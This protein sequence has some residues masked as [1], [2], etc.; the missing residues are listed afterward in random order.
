MLLSRFWDRIRRFA[1]RFVGSAALA[2]AIYLVSGFLLPSVTYRVLSQWH[3]GVKVTIE[4]ER[5]SSAGVS[6]G[7]QVR[8][9]AD[10]K[11]LTFAE[12]S[13]EIDV[14]VPT[15]AAECRAVAIQLR[16]PPDSGCTA[17]G[18]KIA[19][20]VDADWSQSDEARVDAY[21]GTGVTLTQKAGQLGVTFMGSQ[22]ARV[23]LVRNSANS[24]LTLAANGANADI[25]GS[26]GTPSPSDCQ[27]DLVLQ[28]K[29]SRSV[30][31]QSVLLLSGIHKV[32]AT[33]TGTRLETCAASVTKMVA[34]Q[35]QGSV[36]LTCPSD[37]RNLTMTSSSPFSLVTTTSAPDTS[38]TSGTAVAASAS[39]L[40]VNGAEEIPSGWDQY[41]A[42]ISFISSQ[43]ITGGLAVGLIA[44]V[45]STRRRT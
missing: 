45:L 11:H 34:D 29:A 37:G 14:A 26:S 21:T 32:S 41:N 44:F 36:S 15:P 2:V 5:I 19:Q 27:G 28:I 33:L 6:G 43:A 17:S 12:P 42:P 18:L 24:Q 30:P 39:G 23:C 22:V 3:P 7:L 25:N 8:L 31:S 35:P 40:V 13:G 16:I 1:V 9:K 4:L 20:R 38:S 10:A